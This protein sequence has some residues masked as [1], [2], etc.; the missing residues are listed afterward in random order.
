MEVLDEATPFVHS[1]LNKA[2][3]ETGFSDADME[4][5]VDAWVHGPDM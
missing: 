4:I 1:E 5:L 2:A 3:L